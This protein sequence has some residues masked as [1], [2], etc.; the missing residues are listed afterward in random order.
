MASDIPLQLWDGGSF[1]KSSTQS[2]CSEVHTDRPV[3]PL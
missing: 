1:I 2:N 3:S